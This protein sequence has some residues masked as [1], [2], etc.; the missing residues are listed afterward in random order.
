MERFVEAA[1]DSTPG[2]VGHRVPDHQ[3]WMGHTDDQ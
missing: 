3:V 1:N 2:S